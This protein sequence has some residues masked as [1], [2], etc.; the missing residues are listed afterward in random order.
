MKNWLICI[1]VSG[2]CAFSSHATVTLEKT[3][4]LRFTTVF[5]GP[6]NTVNGVQHR[7]LFRARMTTSYLLDGIAWHNGWGIT[8]W[9]RIVQIEDYDRNGNFERLRYV[10][11]DPGFTDRDITSFFTFNWITDESGYRLTGTRSIGP[12]E[13][14][15]RHTETMR[16]NSQGTYRID[17]QGIIRLKGRWI[18]VNDHRIPIH[19]WRGNHT[20]E[21]FFNNTPFSIFMGGMST[22]GLRVLR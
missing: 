20:G 11:R 16:S 17:L 5:P 18:V 15:R 10:I 7:E 12:F 19:N 9:A 8:S 6:T 14:Q 2:L 3:L 22:I 13:V 21:D 4:A 1:F